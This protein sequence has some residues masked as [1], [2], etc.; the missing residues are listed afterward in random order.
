MADLNQQSNTL[1]P[2]VVNLAKSIRQTESNGD[3][4]AVGASG[5]QG[6]YQFTPDT[7]NGTAS[8]YGINVP[9]D[10]AT[11]EQQNAVAYNR[12]KEWKDSGKDVTQIAS[13]WNAG[14]GEPDAY[15]GKFSN[16]QPSIGT[17]KEGVNFDVPKYVASVASTYQ[18]FKTG[19]PAQ[20]TPPT[21]TQ[22]NISP[23]VGALASGSPSTSLSSPNNQT[24]EST[25]S[26]TQNGQSLEQLLFGGGLALSLALAPETG[27]ASLAPE[28][29]AL[30][31]EAGTGS[32]ILG[33]LGNLIKSP[34]STVLEGLGVEK[35]V[36]DIAGSLFGGNKTTDNSQSSQS[37]SQYTPQALQQSTDTSKS[38]T[39]AIMDSLGQTQAGSKIAQ[40]QAGIEGAQTMG[41]YGLTPDV[42]DGRQNWANALNDAG[43]KSKEI[44]DIEN[45]LH[46]AEGA[47]GSIS[48]V[49]SKAK[50]IIRNTLLSTDWAEADKH[51]EN[52]TKGYQSRMG[53]DH[54]PLGSEGIGRIRRE[55]Y[56]GYDRN[57]SSAKNGA[58]KALGSAA[59][60][61]ML[62]QTKHKGLVGGLHKEKQRL[63]YARKVMTHLNGKLAPTHK[64]IVPTLLK[65]YGEYIGI[66]IG[67]KIGGPLGA[68][69]G[70]MIGTH[71]V[72]AVD[73]RYGQS[74][75]QTPA[76]KKGL[77]ILHQKNPH[78]YET[79]VKEL[80]KYEIQV[81]KEQRM[82]QKRKDYKEK[83][84]N[85]EPKNDKRNLY[86]PINELPIIPFG[87]RPKKKSSLPT[88]R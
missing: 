16:G 19:Q 71:L 65:K 30:G 37:S 23:S 69:I 21:N 81:E 68:V 27:G 17:N 40:T 51:I 45:K 33:T 48:E 74:E 35:G 73:K 70:S 46:D 55:G 52:E 32:G 4:S 10:K 54:V 72:R 60:H 62:Q 88:I 76:L 8:K 11:P 59:N 42:V 85:F 49:A 63:E 50:E 20:A 29:G 39:Q 6:S 3:S 12:I 66:S 87:R 75:F 25:P 47:T 41:Q 15:T 78:V 67:N 64:G 18:S 82:E 61:H 53:G 26:T 14:E 58:R 1:D 13:M 43:S 79:V 9:L 2:A 86:K 80:K 44:D 34:V 31:A 28:A 22:S 5:E 36:S 56:K 77:E 24:S 57:A 83:K 7:W 84:S 38:V